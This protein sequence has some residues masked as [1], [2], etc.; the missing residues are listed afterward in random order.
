VNA[1]AGRLADNLEERSRVRIPLAVIHD[2]WAVAAPELTGTLESRGE[3]ASALHELAAAGRLQLP[4]GAWETIPRPS[5]PKF[6]TVPAARPRPRAHRWR[7][8]AWHPTMA[9]VSSLVAVSEAQ[10]DA[11]AAIDAWLRRRDGTDPRPLPVR[12]RSAEIF[13][14]E[15]RLDGLLGSGLFGPGRL[16]LELLGAHRFPPPL[17]LHRVGP[18]PD[19]LIVENADSFWVCREIAADLAGPVG[20]IGW[21]SGRAFVA[22]VAALGLEDQSPRYLW[23]WG[24]LD[25]EGVRIAGEAATAA[26][27]SA[28]PPLQPA[29]PLW[30]GLGA[31]TPEPADL[32]WRNVDSTWL[33][34]MLWA[35][36]AVVRAAGGRV[37]QERLPPAAV[38]AGMAS[39]EVR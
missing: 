17:A 12:V 20:R 7:T 27:R 25:P 13:G 33:G 16:S 26:S 18:G 10:V 29:F 23:Y 34:D 35:A 3:L 24:D 9:W 21:G 32:D 4:A 38:A 15:K 14:R 31:L 1:R 11:L 22:S 28:L 36:T 37:A 30:A 8:M 39:L 2:A 5:L 19:V 6:V